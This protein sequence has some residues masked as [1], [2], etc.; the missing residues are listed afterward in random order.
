M[1][2]CI[3]EGEIVDHEN[4]PLAVLTD[5]TAMPMAHDSATNTFNF[6][7]EDRDLIGIRDYA[8]IAKFE[9]YPTM[10]SDVSQGQIEI[11]DPCLDPD[12]I[13]VFEQTNPPD[14]YYTGLINIFEL[15]AF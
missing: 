3:F 9:N 5:S 8:C 15:N 4:P 10:A 13:Q 11:I 7:A 12:E 14:Y 1:Y 2:D 6:Y